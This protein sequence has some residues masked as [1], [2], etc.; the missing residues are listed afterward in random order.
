MSSPSRV[1]RLVVLV[2]ALL[3]VA[4]TGRLGLWQL[5]RAD[6]K[7]ALQA[8]IDARAAEPPLPPSALALTPEAAAGQHQRRIVLQ[9]RW[10]PEHTVYL[11]NRQQ[12]GRPGFFVLTPFAPEPALAGGAVV[13]VQRGWAPRDNDQRSR[14]PE[15]PTPAG[16]TGVRGRVAPPPARLLQL[17][18]EAA[19]PIRQNLDLDAT[20]AALGRPVLP[21]TIVQTEAPSDGADGLLRDWPP[22]AADVHKH[23][24]YAFQWFALAALVTALYVWF[25]LLRPRRRP[26]P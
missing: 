11:D 20:A 25:Q 14:V 10:L 3:T 23:L 6:Q 22:P 9:G 21:L 24:G 4:I 8:Q 19:G 15:V 17:G 1:R 18:E 5:D 7:R 12:H 13:W 2:A 26:G 16:D